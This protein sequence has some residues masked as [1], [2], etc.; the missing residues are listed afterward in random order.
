MTL[1]D[2][3]DRTIDR[4]RFLSCKGED[5]E[6][7]MRVAATRLEGAPRI[8][9]H[10]LGGELTATEAEWLCSAL[11]EALDFLGV[12]DKRASRNQRERAMFAGWINRMAKR[13]HWARLAIE[14][15]SEDKHLDKPMR[16]ELAKHAEIIKELEDDVKKNATKLGIG[17]QW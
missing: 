7:E 9:L 4:H 13:L 12:A 5:G 3:E 16:K 1:H 8:G 15:R 11:N 10:I 2:L 6:V 14:H 17:A